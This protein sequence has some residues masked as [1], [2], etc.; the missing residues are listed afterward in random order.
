[1]FTQGRNPTS[2]LSAARVLLTVLPESSTSVPTRV[3]ALDHHHHLLSCGL[4][5]HLV[6]Y[7]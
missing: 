3:S 6:L 4:I 7:P 2:V 5:I 1:M